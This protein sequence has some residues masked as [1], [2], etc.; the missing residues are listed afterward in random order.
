MKGARKP[1]DY[2]LRLPRKI[3]A[4]MRKIAAA[5]RR[6]LNFA[7]VQACEEFIERRAGAEGKGGGK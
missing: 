1:F 2:A 4:A 3:H 6:S 7:I 5:D